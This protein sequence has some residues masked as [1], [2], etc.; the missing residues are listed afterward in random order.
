[1]YRRTLVQFGA[2]ILSDKSARKVNNE[3]IPGFEN[4]FITLY[5]DDRG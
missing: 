5:S 3:N 4:I 1:M 2:S